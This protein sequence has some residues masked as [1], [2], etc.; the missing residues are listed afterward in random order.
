MCSVWRMMT[1]LKIEKQEFG[2]LSGNCAPSHAKPQRQTS[3]IYNTG[4]CASDKVRP[5]PETLTNIV[6]QHE[7]KGVCGRKEYVV[8]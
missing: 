7:K 3:C 6:L 4:V 8:Q 2:R 5:E 1:I